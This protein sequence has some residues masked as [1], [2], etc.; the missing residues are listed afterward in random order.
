MLMK[1]TFILFLIILGFSVLNSS[2]I[3]AQELP[4]GIEEQVSIE[5][6]PSVPG[7]NEFVE[8]FITSYLTDLNKA[9]ITWYVNGSVLENGPGVRRINFKTGDLGQTTN[10]RF[11]AQKFGGGVIEKSF[12]V[13]PAEVNIVYESI[14]NT[15]PFYK[16]RSI[17]T[18][19]SL[20]KFA[21][22]P[23]FVDSRGNLI[24][25][26]QIYF[27]WSINGTVNLSGSGIGKDYYIYDPSIIL[28]PIQ[29]QV[30]AS[31]INSTAK[32]RVIENVT[33]NRPF[34]L[35]Y[36]KNPV[37]GT[38]YEQAVNENFLLNR[39]EVEFEVVP[40]FFSTDIFD[41]GKITWSVNGQNSEVGN[42]S[43]SIV[44]RRADENP[45]SVRIGVDVT[46][47]E[48]IIQSDKFDFNLN[49]EEGENFEF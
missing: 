10:V 6:N 23:N 30:I 19:E 43:P 34:N 11:V 29:V 9:N 41:F 48:K 2:N 3:W 33:L 40:Y 31:P 49:Y 20:L 22:I 25:S 1:K 16:G 39:K 32:A 42:N 38:I 21:A 5:I 46:H 35:V 36:E 12:S 15:P 45:G 13:T 4:P 47:N 27:E 26:S 17:A 24:P 37:F 7:A 18:T 14:T 28:R 8:V 44:F